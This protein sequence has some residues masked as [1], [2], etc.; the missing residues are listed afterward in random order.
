MGE[1][2]MIRKIA[3]SAWQG[4]ASAAIGGLMIVPAGPVLAQDALLDEVVVTAR[5][6]EESLQNIPLAITAFSAEAMERRT[7][8]SLSD[9]ALLTPGLSFESFAGG[10]FGVPTIRGATQQNITVLEQNVSVFLDGVYLPRAWLFD[11]GSDDM[12][13]IEVMKGPQG[14]L[15]GQNAFMGA[16]N[17]VTAK[18]GDEF[19]ARAKATVGD[20]E[21]YEGSASVNL[22]LIPG[23]LAVR[24]SGFYSTYDGAWKNNHPLA[25]EA[26]PGGTRGN[27]G[28]WDKHAEGIQVRLTPNESLTID[29]AYRHLDLRYG[30]TRKYNFSGANLLSSPVASVGARNNCSTRNAT[31]GFGFWCGELPLP[32][33]ATFAE[34]PRQRGTQSET[35]FATAS[36]AWKVSEAAGLSYSYGRVASEALQI[37]AQNDANLFVPNANIVFQATPNSDMTYEQHELRFDFQ[38]SDSVRFTLG[39]FYATNDD[40]NVFLQGNVRTLSTTPVTLA[41]LPTVIQNTRTD[42][43]S[44]AVFGSVAIGLLDDRARLTVEGRNTWSDKS[45]VGTGR[46]EETFFDPRV[47]FDFNLSDNSLLYGSVARGTKAGGLNPQPAVY[48]ALGGLRENERSFEPD[49]NWSYELGSKNRLLGDRLTLNAALFYVKWD[50]MQVSSFSTPPPGFVIPGGP[51]AAP[52]IVLNLGNGTIQGVEIE[53]SLRLMDPLMLSFGGS[54]QNAEYDSG[55][56]ATRIIRACDGIVCG[57]DIGGNQLARS[58]ES[59]AFLGL[60]WEQPLGSGELRYYL[61]GDL[62]WQSKQFTD[63]SNSSWIPARTLTNLSLGLKQGERWEAQLWGKNVA[64]EKYITAAYFGPFL[65]SIYTP[66]LGQRR[67]F[68][69]SLTARF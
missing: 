16:I 48:A 42:V 56:P 31:F 21:M 17:Y 68:G 9:V 18:P 38:K 14:T 43:S 2:T 13:R 10:G 44:K 58:P 57:A 5:K 49:R 62:A 67:T 29:A 39:G 19:A 20:D 40:L 35:D 55:T 7:I 69:L 63:E 24:V 36:V 65:S 6:R 50:D 52:Q 22:P 12:A 1:F 30:P 59:Q 25:N 53:G 28:G 66:L 37:N 3:T 61:H 32:N 4:V 27:F 45:V 11:V 23:K 47:T 54:F 46:T 60:D 8:S 15:Y 51:L 26:I 33:F 34:D 41:N 64:D